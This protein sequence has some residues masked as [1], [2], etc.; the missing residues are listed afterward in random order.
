METFSALLAICAGNLSVIGEFPSQR[1]VTRSFDVFFD[2]CLNKQLS[3]QL[4]GWW[5]ETPSRSL[6]RHCYD[7]NVLRLHGSVLHWFTSRN[8]WISGCGM[9]KQYYSYI[10][11]SKL[12]KLWFLYIAWQWKLFPD[13][14]YANAYRSICRQT[15][16]SLIYITVVNNLNARN[17]LM[18][19]MWKRF[20]VH[21]TIE[22]N[23]SQLMLSRSI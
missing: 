19:N 6:W 7:Y 22:L 21:Q 12:L 10:R 1:P 3:K 4:W 20:V 15:G 5:F 9:L 14:S 18:L 23:I 2:L 13:L 16:S 11:S 8:T 17:I